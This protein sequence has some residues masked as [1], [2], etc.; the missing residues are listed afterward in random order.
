MRSCNPSGND[1]GTIHGRAPAEADHGVTAVFQIL[2]VSLFDIVNRGVRQNTVID[3]VAHTDSLKRLKKTAGQI[4]LHQ[5]TVCN[6]KRL[7]NALR[8]NQRRKFS[9]T[10]RT[11]QYRA[12]L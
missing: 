5:D 12:V 7:L 2:R 10:S 9:D 8:L 6:D 3:R 1:L 4:S 11:L